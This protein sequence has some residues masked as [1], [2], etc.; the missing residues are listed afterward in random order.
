[1]SNGRHRYDDVTGEVIGEKGAAAR[2][3]AGQDDGRFRVAIAGYDL[4]P[5]TISFIRA[6]SDVDFCRIT[7]VWDEDE[8]HLN[9]LV[10]LTGAKGYRDLDEFCRSQD[11]DGA[12]VTVSTNRRCEVVK[13]LA[14]GSKHVLSDKP[15]AMNARECQEM[16]QA[17]K[18][19]GVVISGGYNFR[20]WKTWP[21]MKRIMDTGE[22]G[23]P[24]HFYCAYNTG[25]V[26]RN[27]WENT[28]DSYWTDPT[29]TPGG[30]WLTH[31]DHPI[32]LCRWLFR[33][34]FT[35]VLADMRKLRYP[36]YEVEDYGVAHYLLSNGA[37]AVIQS[38]AI[39]PSFRL[40]VI[41]IC[42]KGGMAYSAVPDRKLKVW[43]VPSL[44]SN[45][46]E[47]ALADDNWVEALGRLTKSLVEAVQKGAPLLSTAEDNLRVMEVVD[48][49][50]QSAREG[51]KVQIR[52]HVVK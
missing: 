44:G 42:Q 18:Q 38:D 26:R 12:I 3:A 46:V 13:A 50:Y 16:I 20:F 8:R 28:Y 19:A 48:A 10:E 5:H 30:G 1:M 9:R 39:A 37:T 31:G 21:L 17:C 34:E 51:R 2:T 49:T 4:W 24:V 15:M 36:Q 52:Q 22:L 7:A 35:E 41:V 45:V 33:C 11:F 14:A 29:T 27:E 32:D 43:G 23:E 47:Y 25:M 6:L 40:D